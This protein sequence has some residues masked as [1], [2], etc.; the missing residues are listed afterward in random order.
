MMTWLNLGPPTW[1]KTNL[2]FTLFGSVW[3][4]KRGAFGRTSNDGGLWRT[5]YG[6]EYWLARAP[7][8]LEPET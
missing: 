2:A 1:A 6:V 4:G 8:N 7:A 3:A 5:I